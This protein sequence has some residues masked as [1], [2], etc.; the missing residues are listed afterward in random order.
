MTGYI[1]R[2][3]KSW[4]GRWY[5]DEL[6]RGLDGSSQVVRKQHAEKLCSVSDRYRSKK[7]VQPLLDA[8]LQL[9]N[10]G[11]ARSE[12]TLS[13]RDYTEDYFLPYVERELKPST[14]YG[15]RSLWRM[16]LRPQLADIAMRDFRCVDATNVLSSIHRDHSIGRSTLRHC[17]AMMSTI[18]AYA[19]RSGV[20]DGPNP[21]QDSG[22]PRAAAT[23]KPTHAYSPEEVLAM[24]NALNGVART[25]VALM[26]FCGLRPG[27]ARAARWEDYDGK[28]L[29]IRASMWRQH[30][31]LPKTAESCASVPVKETLAQILA[32]APRTSEYILA[33]P[34]G[35]PVDLHNLAFRTICPAL[36][37]CAECHKSRKEHDEDGHKFKPLPK[38]R[39]FYAC[40]RGCATL[41]TAVDSPLA[42]KSLLRHSNIQTTA[43]YYIKSIG[44]EADRAA[45]KMNA[46]FET[47]AN[48]AVN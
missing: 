41:A 3:G 31:T 17:K 46:L 21:A 2:V 29:R 27:E 8:K 36:A 14:T 35:R 15:Y 6:S 9:I 42:A 22:I 12:S 7:D 30:L 18:F 24:L 33:S 37:G 34:T 26:Y 32:E 11:L 13:V 44:A 4:Y 1:W 48:E 40:R 23:S 10:E 38:W 16:Y 5:R 47:T 25:A 43:Q 19:K 39:G 20:L 28:T 45:E